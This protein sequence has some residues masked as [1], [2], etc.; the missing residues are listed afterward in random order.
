MHFTQPHT[1]AAIE[2]QIKCVNS[3]VENAKNKRISQI[4]A[5]KAKAKQTN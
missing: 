3:L 2:W 1:F 4:P 5:A